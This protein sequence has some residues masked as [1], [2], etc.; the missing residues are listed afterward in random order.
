ME[1]QAASILGVLI[2][3]GIIWIA[4][5]VAQAKEQLTVLRTLLVGENGNNGL[6]SEVKGLRSR[7]HDIA[8]AV[9][10]VGGRVEVLD[11][12]IAAL[13]KESAA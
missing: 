1:E 8:N 13:E 10:A 3:T 2:L 6:A 4:R 11:F 7:Q 12:R 9:Q 5:S